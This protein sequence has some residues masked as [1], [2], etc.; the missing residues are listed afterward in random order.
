MRTL[1]LTIMFVA[2]ALC[3]RAQKGVDIANLSLSEN[4]EQP[5]VQG[6][7]QKPIVAHMAGIRA[8][9]AK[10]FPAVE[11]LRQG[12]V[13]AVD[14]PA[15]LLFAPNGVELLEGGKP[16]LRPFLSMLRYPTMYKLLVVMHSDDTGDD[17][18]A[19]A[20]TSDRA[21]AIGDFLCRE[22]GQEGGNV[23]AYGVGKD[24]PVQPNNS[25]E[26][27]AANRR[28]ELYIVPQ[29]QLIDQAKS[30]KLK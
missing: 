7:A 3:C 11:L 25:I 30:G 21:S 18:Y 24:D 16:Y 10:H 20:L 17:Q 2:A 14:I 9:L 26:N 5:A 19:D 23:V 1:V 8:S 22:S 12:Q 4:L 13:V 29:W 6:K 27:R 28:L 15:S